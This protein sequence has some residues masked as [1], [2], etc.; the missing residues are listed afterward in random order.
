MS[1]ANISLLTLTVVAAGVIAAYRAVGFDDLQA[2]V[3]GQKIKGFAKTAAAA[4]GDA[5]AVEAK[6]TVVAE[7]GG[8]FTAGDAL[9]IDANG[10]VV[11]ADPLA[12]A[13]PTINAGG[14]A[15]TSTA[16]NGD[17]TT[18]GAITGGYLPQYVFADAL[19][20]SG[21]AGEFVEILMR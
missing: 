17:V 9:T 3:A 10:R 1:R 13:D 21:G 11:A 20:D 8:A 16:A 6:G 7:T 4:I 2:T 15:V 12:V 19:E 14:V 5:I 18:Q